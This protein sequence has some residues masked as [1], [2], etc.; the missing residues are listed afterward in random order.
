M[1]V[2]IG[3]SLLDEDEVAEYET[4]RHFILSDEHDA[5][6]ASHKMLHLYFYS[7]PGPPWFYSPTAQ[8]FT[9][10][11]DCLDPLPG[12]QIVLCYGNYCFQ[13]AMPFGPADN[14]RLLGKTVQLPR[15]PLLVPQE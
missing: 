6:F 12:K 14:A 8:L 5:L 15:F 13:L 11:A 3:L 1:L 7:L 4:A 9:L 2:K 10:A